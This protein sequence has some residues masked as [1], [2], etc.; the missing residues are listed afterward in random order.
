MKSFINRAQKHFTTGQFLG[1]LAALFLGIVTVAYAVTL[2][3]TFT[4]GTAISSSQVNANFTAL[5]AGLPLVRAQRDTTDLGTT[6]T[7]VGM[8]Q[9][10]SVSITAPVDGILV[11]SGTAFANNDSAF[12]VD[13]ALLARVD[14]VGANGVTT[15]HAWV[16]MPAN[17]VGDQTTLSYTI[18]T[19]IT[20]GIHTVSQDMGPVSGTASFFHN[21]ESLVVMFFPSS[22]GTVT[23]LSPLTFSESTLSSEEGSPGGQ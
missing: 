17:G 22:Q 18:A 5:N 13:M 1:A 16:D 11:I 9:I 10:N 20:A 15:M 4:A 21:R 6:E 23:I 12:P 3:N 14:G 7:N 8:L 2:P 19:L